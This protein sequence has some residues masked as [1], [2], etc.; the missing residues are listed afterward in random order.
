MQGVC[1]WLQRKE[2]PCR[3]SF[4]VPWSEMQRKQ[5]RTRRAGWLAHGPLRSRCPRAAPNPSFR[6]YAPVLTASMGQRSHSAG[7][8]GCS[9][10]H[11]FFSVRVGGSFTLSH[12]IAISCTQDCLLIPG[13]LCRIVLLLIRLH[14]SFILPHLP[15]SVVCR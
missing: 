6:G 14:S 4:L 2:G 3:P 1:Q 13:S 7:Y 15:R 12:F 9:T 11:P 5:K 8:L 10:E